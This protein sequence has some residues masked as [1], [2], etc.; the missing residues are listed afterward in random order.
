MTTDADAESRPVMFR[1]IPAGCFPFTIE[2]LDPA[3][4]E[5][6]GVTGVQFGDGN[7]QT[8]VF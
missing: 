5:V 7:S 1:D 4:R 3:T 6:H 2:L 8:N